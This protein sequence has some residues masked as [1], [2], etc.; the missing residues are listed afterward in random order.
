MG[1]DDIEFG[2]LIN[3]WNHFYKTRSQFEPVLLGK[4]R[5]TIYVTG[6]KEDY[7]Y[8]KLVEAGRDVLPYLRVLCE[9]IQNPDPKNVIRLE[10]SLVYHGIPIL[11]QEVSEYEIPKNIKP[12]RIF[13]DCYNWLEK[14]VPVQ[15]NLFP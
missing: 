3:E 4:E 2:E 13:D 6:D 7:A 9:K 11:V 12:W 8:H 1:I 10:D 14:N 15:T 5:K